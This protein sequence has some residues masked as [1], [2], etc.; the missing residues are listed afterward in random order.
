MRT[1]GTNTRNSH[2]KSN[3]Y[4]GRKKRTAFKSGK[5]NGRSGNVETQRRKKREKG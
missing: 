4:C 2:V 3:I 1:S 5:Y